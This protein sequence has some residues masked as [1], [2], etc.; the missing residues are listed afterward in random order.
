MSNSFGTLFKITTFG[1]SHGPAI[2][3]VI[4]GIPPGV[5]LSEDDIQKDLDRRRPG[6][7]KITTQRKESD[8]AEILSGVFE[9]KTMGTPVAILIRNEDQRS[10]DYSNLKDV[11]RPGHADYTYQMKYGMRDYRGGG[12]SSGRETACRVAA[13]AVAKKILA[14]HKIE[15]IV[16]TL[17]VGNITAK[18]KDFSVI[19]KNLV[20]TCDLDAAEKMIKLIEDARKD[21]D[22]VGG[23]I[24]AVIK[25]CP[26]GL[27][28]PIYDKLNARLAY[29]LMSIGTMRGVEFGDGFAA[30][31]LKGSE[32]ND[33]FFTKGKEVHTKTNHAGGILGGISDGEDIILR[34]GVK[35]PSS[36]AKNQQTVDIS[37]EDTEV[38][39]KG[40]HDPCICP[41]VV[42][43]V[44]AMI[45]VVLV[46]ALLIQKTIK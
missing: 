6:Q 27:G 41:R 22:S 28:N 15:I 34:V 19:E 46:D 37:G 13:G 30:T 33:I 29:A 5:S 7:S 44:E 11:F 4:D 20:R 9:G 18:K 8:K 43:V 10:K 14:S 36:I 2:G 35:P 12:R 39:V 25:G 23:V 45:A 16:Y 26:A 32:H 1:E 24:E 40:R 31:Q 38:Q 3:V 17:S 21:C 42:P